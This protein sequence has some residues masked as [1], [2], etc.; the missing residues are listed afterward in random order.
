MI[1]MKD[2]RAIA[3]ARLRDSRVLL[4]AKRFDAARYLSGYAIEL[5]L[6]ARICRTLKWPGF[7]ESA[8]ELDGLQS[9]KTHDLKMLLQLSGIEKQV[10]AKCTREWAVVLNW[11]PEKRY[12][13]NGLSTL[14]QTTEMIE[15]VKRLLEVL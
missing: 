11:N 7:P 5:A 8:R 3:R 1:S 9:V 13:A 12:Q 6:K 2:L 14:Q 15:C 4:A 10:T